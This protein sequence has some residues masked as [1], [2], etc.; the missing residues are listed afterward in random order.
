MRQNR[1][2]KRQRKEE[3]GKTYA[4]YTYICKKCNAMPCIFH[5]MPATPCYAMQWDCMDW[6]KWNALT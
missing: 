1:E 5:T 6:L 3:K 2:T 4:I